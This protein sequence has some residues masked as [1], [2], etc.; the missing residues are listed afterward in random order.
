MCFRTSLHKQLP[1][2]TD[3]DVFRKTLIKITQIAFAEF[4]VQCRS[5]SSNCKVGSAS[6]HD[7]SKGLANVLNNPLC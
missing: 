1:S 2:A 7:A 6:L 4:R 5:I 3:S